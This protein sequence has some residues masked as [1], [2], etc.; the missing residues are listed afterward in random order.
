M[1]LGGYS[2]E[3]ELG[4]GGTGIVFRARAR[5]GR[6]VAVKLLVD[7]DAETRERF[8]REKR[9]LASLGEAQG[10]VPFLDAGSSPR[11]PFTVMPLIPGGTLRD[12][13]R[14]GP[15]PHAD[16]L[17]LG[18]ALASAV[19]CAHAL[20]IVHRDIKPENVLF[21]ADGRPL[22]ADLGLAKRVHGSSGSVAS[23]SRSGEL[24]GTPGY[25]SAEQIRDAKHAGPP[26]DVFALGVT[27][28]ECLSGGKPFEGATAL[29]VFMA[30]EA[31]RYARLGPR[32]PGAP[33][34][35]VRAVERALDSDPER[36]FQNGSE[37]AKALE[38]I[39]APAA[40][41]LR[42]PLVAAAGLVILAAGAFAIV[43]RKGAPDP[44]IARSNL[45]PVEKPPVQA[46]VLKPAVEKPTTPIEP[47]K[48]ATAAVTSP[49]AVPSP[50]PIVSPLPPEDAASF[51][52][53]AEE[54]VKQARL[55]E[56]IAALSSAIALEPGNGAFHSRRAGFRME[57]GDNEGALA[58]CNRAIELDP[59]LAWA[60]ANRAELRL[61]SGDRDGAF[62]D[63]SKAL[64]ID[65]KIASSWGV[66]GWVLAKRQDWPNAL[67]AADRA[68]AL[69]PK[70]GWLR[71][72]RAAIKLATSDWRGALE[73]A[74]VGL[75]AL[76]DDIEILTIEARAELQLD[77]RPGAARTLR[78]IL[79]LAP[80]LSNKAEVEAKIAELERR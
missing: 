67:A 18:R 41:S 42:A 3:G 21:T 11:G 72:T 26:T 70:T 16:V 17:A 60:F 5:D 10:F 54:L 24:G 22:L 80:N 66:K 77:D 28:Y 9:L 38:S 48:G 12:R 47:A 27:L 65:D 44:P 55:P 25:M 43:P 59:R 75:E 37:L 19:G 63:A 35:L 69:A 64:A 58:D 30:V 73:D 14:H 40:R 4:R 74:R 52:A 7:A 78:R 50:V 6:L 15:L 2:I 39:S 57:M 20:G 61:P 33:A 68:I 79:E 56:A 71:Q 46:A 23:I 29:E 51:A 31:G 76:P 34:A 53:R 36:R 8:E 1:E 49:V 62:E 45:S 13:L 32:C